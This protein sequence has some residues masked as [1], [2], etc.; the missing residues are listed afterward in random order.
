MQDFTNEIID[1]DSLPRYEEAP[2][3]ALS[4]KY[5][6]VIL[7]NIVIVLLL[8]V[9]GVYAVMWIYEILLPYSYVFAI[10]YILFA[11]GLIK[12]Y[13][14]SFK[15]RGF[16]VR[17]KDLIYTSGVLSAT[18]TIVPFNRVQ[19]VALNEGVFSRMYKLGTLEVFTAGGATGNLKVHGLEISEANK[20]KELLLKRVDHAG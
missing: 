12:I 5:W 18:T 20:L 1:I 10:I 2:L 7:I 14:I 9:S 11:A 6:N 3:K 4:S 8:L 13:S 19:H 16:T 15:R 17:E